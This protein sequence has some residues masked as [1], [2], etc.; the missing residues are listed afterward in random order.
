M[1]ETEENFSILDEFYDYEVIGPADIKTR[2][3]TERE[4]Q[5]INFSYKSKSK[6]IFTMQGFI[7]ILLSSIAIFCIW[8]SVNSI[9]KGEP[10]AFMHLFIACALSLFA[11]ALS[12]IIYV[13][14]LKQVISKDEQIAPGEIVYTDI[15]RDYRNTVMG[16]YHTIA[17]HGNKQ[18]IKIFDR[19]VIKKGK[20]VLVI[21]K[22]N[23]PPYMIRIPKEAVDYDLITNKCEYNEPFSDIEEYSYTIGNL[24]TIAYPISSEENEK[25]VLKECLLSPFKHGVISM[26]WMFF[27]IIT[28]VM[29]T[30]LIKS[31]FSNESEIFFPLLIGFLCEIFIECMLCKIVFKK[32]VSY[33][34]SGILECVIIKKIEDDNIDKK[35][36]SV[37]IPERKQFVNLTAT[38][39]D[40]KRLSLNERVTLVVNKSTS[41]IRYVIRK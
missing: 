16:A 33:Q 41:E 31:F 40:Y 26:I 24:E 10:D 39:F 37:A 22:H 32:K 9:I 38:H 11:I 15:K 19:H 21:V 30:F 20:T 5:A 8:S 17:L 1:F 35:Y 23:I 7:L 13:E 29:L 28:I 6:S 14:R 27:T 12:S 25:I 3:I 18:I 36:I 2:S 4:Y 34:D